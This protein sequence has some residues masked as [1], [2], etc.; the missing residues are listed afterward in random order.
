MTD[1]VGLPHPAGRPRTS[2]PDGVKRLMRRAKPLP[3]AA[4]LALI[5]LA[6]CFDAGSARIKVVDRTDGLAAPAVLMRSEAE[7]QRKLVGRTVRQPGSSGYLAVLH[8]GGRGQVWL[9]GRA[10]PTEPV[11]WKILNGARTMTG[12]PSDLWFICLTYPPSAERPQSG[13]RCTQADLWQ[14]A[15][16]A[17]PPA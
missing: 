11:A 4:P 12:V 5:G 10:A 8:P 14:I 15:E 2:H 13:E 6:G 3:I 1:P 7:V 16:G 17:Q 9:P